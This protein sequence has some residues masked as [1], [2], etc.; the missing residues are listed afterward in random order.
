MRN[1]RLTY[2]A[3]FVKNLNEYFQTKVCILRMRMGCQQEIETLISEEAL[4]FA[5]YLRN[6]KAI[7][8]PRIVLA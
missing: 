3:V 8:L 2:S 1:I 7:W 5:E 6:E 4:L